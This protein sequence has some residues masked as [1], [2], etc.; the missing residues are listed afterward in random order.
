MKKRRKQHFIVKT[1]CTKRKVFLSYDQKWKEG[2]DERKK[3]KEKKEEKKERK[4]MQMRERDKTGLVASLA[5][6][7]GSIHPFLLSLSSVTCY[8]PSFSLSLS[9]CLKWKEKG[10]KN[11]RRRKKDDYDERM[12]K[13]KKRSS[14]LE[15]KEEEERRRKKVPSRLNSGSV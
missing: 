5:S 2:K 1:I 4:K 8:T 13:K 10:R 3:K 11:E 14:Y 7:E 12:K 15:E 6:L 9:L